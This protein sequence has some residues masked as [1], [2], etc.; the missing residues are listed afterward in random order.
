MN[1]AVNIAAIIFYLV[2]TGVILFGGICSW[3][4]RRRWIKKQQEE[5]EFFEKTFDKVIEGQRKTMTETI[6]KNLEN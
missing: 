1:L 6:S 4:D 3:R 2:A 5:M